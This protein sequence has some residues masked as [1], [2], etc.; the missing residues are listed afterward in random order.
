MIRRARSAWSCALAASCA[1]SMAPMAYAQ[2]RPDAAQRWSMPRDRRRPNELH[3]SF[4][5]TFAIGDSTPNRSGLLWGY[6]LAHTFR[7]AITYGRVVRRQFVLGATT[8]FAGADGG[9]AR[10]DGAPLRYY[11]AGFG[12]V[13]AVRSSSTRDGPVRAGA[14][15][16]ADAEVLIALTSLRGELGAG[17]G[18]RLGARFGVELVVRSFVASACVGFEWQAYGAGGFGGH[19]IFG[20]TIPVEVG[21]RW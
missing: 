3:A 2:R 7:G 20:P 13:A 10:F 15:L 9:F 14:L 16:R 5:P 6:A 21:Y 11:W 19:M 4:V 8:S 17:P 1:L 18:V 12:A